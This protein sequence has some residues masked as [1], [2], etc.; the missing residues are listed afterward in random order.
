MNEQE[1]INLL[2]A[3]PRKNSDLWEA[4]EMQNTRL[5]RVRAM[6]KKAQ[7]KGLPVDPLIEKLDEAIQYISNV[8]KELR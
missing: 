4:W 6:F 3:H 2:K 8:Q 5:D 7:K 1:I